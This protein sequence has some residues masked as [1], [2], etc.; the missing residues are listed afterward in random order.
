[1]EKTLF[2]KF[3]DGDLPC[4]KVWESSTHLAFLTPFANTKGQTIV[5]PKK[6]P[7]D[8]IFKMEDSHMIDLMLATKQVAKLLEKAFSVDRVGVIFEGEGVPHIHAKLYPMHG[9]YKTNLH[10]W[11]HPQAFFEKYPGY[12]TSLEGPKMSDSDLDS[13]QSQIISAQK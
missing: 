5:V 8:N 4:W 6:S 12:L 9:D 7:G 11:P 10:N 3:A 1:M 13:I 2:E